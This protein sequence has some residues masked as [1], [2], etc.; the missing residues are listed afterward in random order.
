VATS[1]PGS[2]TRNLLLNQV[3]SNGSC[4]RAD[5][6]M[7][8][9]HSASASTCS[10][11][12]GERAGVEQD[13]YQCLQPTR[14]WVAATRFPELNRPQV[15]AQLRGQVALGQACAAAQPKCHPGEALGTKFSLHVS[16]GIRVF[17]RCRQLTPRSLARADR[18]LRIS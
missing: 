4:N 12:P 7:A 6:I 2:P 1:D 5:S 16:H 17:A 3:A 15:H 18:S 8:A 9:F 10:R 13:F 11:P 14:L